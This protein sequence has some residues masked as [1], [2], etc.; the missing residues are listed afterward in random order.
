MTTEEIQ[1]MPLR[2][3]VL[4]LNSMTMREL[5]DQFPNRFHNISAKLSQ[6]ENVTNLLAN[7][8][9]LWHLVLE[10]AKKNNP[11]IK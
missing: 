2:E 10:H 4:W 3:F 1:A 11:I 5:F 7:E 9:I 8:A 6:Q